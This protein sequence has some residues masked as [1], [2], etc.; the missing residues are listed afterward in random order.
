M[1]GPQECKKPRNTDES[2]DLT[3]YQN[4][5]TDSRIGASREVTMAYL[6]DVVDSLQ[7]D[8]VAM[9]N[10]VAKLR[11]VVAFLTIKN[12]VSYIQIDGSKN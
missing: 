9:Q 3:Y 7:E 2:D 10:A 11:E 5:E 4:Q 12:D 8:Y 6:I 1:Q